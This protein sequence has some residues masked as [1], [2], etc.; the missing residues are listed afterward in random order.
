MSKI[1]VEEKSWSFNKV[2]CVNNLSVSDGHKLMSSSHGCIWSE[3]NGNHSITCLS[4]KKEKFT[5]FPMMRYKKVLILWSRSYIVIGKRSVKLVNAVQ[6][7]WLWNTK[8]RTDIVM[9]HVSDFERSQI[10]GCKVMLWFLDHL[11]WLC[12][13]HFHCSKCALPGKVITASPCPEVHT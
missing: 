10:K 12:N 3:C 11:I 5:L 4:S 13:T 8:C 6:S 9:V 7:L 2:C 1:H